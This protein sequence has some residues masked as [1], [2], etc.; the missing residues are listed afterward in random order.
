MTTEFTK[1]FITGEL[2]KAQNATARPWRMD[3]DCAEA[4]R[5]GVEGWCETPR[6]LRDTYGELEAQVTADRLFADSAA[7]HYEA[8]LRE[9][10]RLQYEVED[11]QGV[12]DAGKVAVYQMKSRAEAADK[13]VENARMVLKRCAA[14]LDKAVDYVPC[15]MQRVETINAR[16]MAMNVLEG[17]EE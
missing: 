10:E 5:E 8:A 3:W 2:E 4:A 17:G 12:V 1:D 16:N 14:M 11:R 13:K 9:I 6:V 15:G 7:N